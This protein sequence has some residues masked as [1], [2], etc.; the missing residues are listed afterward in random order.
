MIAKLR[1][2]QLTSRKLLASDSLLSSGLSDR[3][4]CMF[5]AT[6]VRGAVDRTP[7]MHFSRFF[8]P[9]ATETFRDSKPATNTTTVCTGRFSHSKAQ[10]AK[11]LA[12]IPVAQADQQR[13][14]GR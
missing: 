12:E 13:L 11:D 8:R 10:E 2:P 9:L 5:R 6:P 7:H 3:V 1:S 4:E 14:S